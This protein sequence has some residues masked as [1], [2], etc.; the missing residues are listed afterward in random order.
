MGN[1][2]TASL[3]AQR[4][5]NAALISQRQRIMKKE[6]EIYDEIL[7]REVQQREAEK[8]EQTIRLLREQQLLRR[9]RLE[10]D[11]VELRKQLLE[12]QVRNT[13]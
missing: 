12:Q 3:D 6:E 8:R 2:L 1:Y 7:K 4:S 11:M 13:K 9:D 5:E 10:A